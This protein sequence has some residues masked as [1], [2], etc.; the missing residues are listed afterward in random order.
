M[1]FATLLFFALQ[2]RC[3]HAGLSNYQSSCGFYAGQ[4]ELFYFEWRYEGQSHY[5]EH[6]IEQADGADVCVR[7]YEIYGRHHYAYRGDGQAK[8]VGAIL[9]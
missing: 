9:G 3:Y 8:V 7:A 1:A 6:Y 5:R 2:G 4:T